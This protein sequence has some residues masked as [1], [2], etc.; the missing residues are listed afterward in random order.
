MTF[1][2][3]FLA[4]AALAMAA[5][6]SSCITDDKDANTEWLPTFADFNDLGYWSGCYDTDASHVDINGLR[7]SHSASSFEWDGVAYCSWNGFC[8][9][10]ATDNADYSDGDW[11]AHQWTS[12][13]GGGVAGEGSPYVVGFWKTD[14]GETSC[15]LTMADGSVF[16]P[17][18]M[19]ITNTS[20]GYY[21]MKNGT[22]FSH[23]FTADDNC[24]LQINGYLNGAR[25]YSTVYVYLAK[26]T[27][28]L[29]YWKK[30]EVSK[31]GNVDT[32]VF[33]MTSTDS[34]QWG[35]NNPAYFCIGSMRYNKVGDTK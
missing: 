6:F 34:G 28:I 9:S 19:Y 15:R 21:A 8:P 10:R 30:V 3:L 7:L 5:S 23:A 26:G 16:Y 32:I 17:D 22:H 33:T 35:M 20:Y 25:K 31:L 2:H 24:V 14:G 4:S 29:D 1:N 18:D 13:T 27:D 11:T 12:I